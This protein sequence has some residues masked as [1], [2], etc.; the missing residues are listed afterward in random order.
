MIF[1]DG[2]KYVGQFLSGIP[3]KNSEENKDENY[4]AKSVKNDNN[5]PKYRNLKL[6][7]RYSESLIEKNLNV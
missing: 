1:N 3:H 7:A 6:K 2:S 4:S 5:T